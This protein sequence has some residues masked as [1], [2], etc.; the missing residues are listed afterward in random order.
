MF[1]EAATKNPNE[2]LPTLPP[3]ATSAPAPNAPPV[4]GPAAL[5]ANPSTEVTLAVPVI[6][7]DGDQITVGFPSL[8]GDWVLIAS[9]GT[10]VTLQVGATVGIYTLPYVATDSAGASATSTV[11]V[12]VTA[13]GGRPRPP[14][15]PRRPRSRPARSDR[16]W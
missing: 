10:T 12:D 6:D 16:S 7:P 15:P 13:D 1:I 8:P 9:S 3:T 4:A 2:T 11:T 5:S 14:A